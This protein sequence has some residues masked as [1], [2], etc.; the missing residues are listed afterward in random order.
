MNLELALEAY[1]QVMKIQ[2]YSLEVSN[3]ILWDGLSQALTKSVNIWIV[4]DS[5]G[6]FQFRTK[7]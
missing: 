5:D 3:Y 6:K 2:R 7:V 4:I 1:C